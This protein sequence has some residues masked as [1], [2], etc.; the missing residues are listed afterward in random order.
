MHGSS[1]VAWFE[2]LPQGERDLVN[3]AAMHAVWD[4]ND[5]HDGRMSLDDLRAEIWGLHVAQ[6]GD[7]RVDEARPTEHLHTAHFYAPSSGPLQG[8]TPQTDR[9][10]RSTEMAAKI[11]EDYAK[12]T[13]QSVW[14]GSEGQVTV[15]T[16]GD[17]KINTVDTRLRLE[18]HQGDGVGLV[19][20][21]LPGGEYVATTAGWRYL[22]RVVVE[23]HPTL[24]N[25]TRGGGE[26]RP[27]ERHTTSWKIVEVRDRPWSDS[28]R[29]RT[30]QVSH[31]FYMPV[32]AVV[33]HIWVEPEPVEGVEDRRVTLCDEPLSGTDGMI[34]CGVEIVTEGDRRRHMHRWE[35]KPRKDSLHAQI[36]T[37]TDDEVGE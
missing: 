15:G 4:R 17:V 5:E 30:A 19:R 13:G 32:G 12:L 6:F 25:P 21:E 8:L 23:P 14:R 33:K 7:V 28:I 36:Y 37:W 31:Q 27:G 18:P 35:G 10:L 9:L 2:S 1:F 34:R 11:A 16:Y 26:G 24:R 22:Q 29:E 3:M 20:T